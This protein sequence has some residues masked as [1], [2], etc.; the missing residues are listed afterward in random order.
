MSDLRNN[1]HILWFII[2]IISNSSLISIN[3]GDFKLKVE[4]DVQV[5]CR[6]RSKVVAPNDK[7]DSQDLEDQEQEHQD[8]RFFLGIFNQL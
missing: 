3:S 8:P 5:K 2:L 6:D 1:K 4:V 7:V